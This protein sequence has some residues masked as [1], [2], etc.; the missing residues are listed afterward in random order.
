MPSKAM[1][2]EET[3]QVPV[4]A[5]EII[6]IL[7]R[8]YPGEVEKAELL[9]QSGL[10]DSDLRGVLDY[11]AQEGQLDPDADEFK[12]RD[13]SGAGSAPPEDFPAEED[14]EAEDELAEQPTVEATTPATDGSLL[15]RMT[16]GVIVNFSR[17]PGE[18]DDA[19]NR[20][21]LQ[22]SKKVEEAIRSDLPRLGVSVQVDRLEAWGAP[23]V[24]FPPE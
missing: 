6:L 11:L 2:N 20:K 17:S 4:L 22:V 9:D 15:A 13:P 1:A 16:L 10:S 24:I 14:E 21:A 12:W 7:Q 5:D 8:A 18:S 19:L 23:R 3:A